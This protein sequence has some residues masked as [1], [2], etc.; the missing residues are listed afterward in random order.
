MRGLNYRDSFGEGS[1]IWKTEDGGENWYELIND[2]PQGDHVGRIGLT[3]SQSSPNVLYAFYD[4]QYGIEIYRTQD[5][6]E[7]WNRT[8]DGA[9]DG[10]NSSFG[11]YFGQIRVMPTSE[12]G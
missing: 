4:N 12:P 5:N 11:W 9:L 7:S 8:N 3:I 2:L 6:G 1:G 10:I